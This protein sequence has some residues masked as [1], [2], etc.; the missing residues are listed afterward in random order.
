MSAYGDKSFN[1]TDQTNA[2]KINYYKRS[3][4]MYNSANMLQGRVRK[5]HNFTGKR[6]DLNIPLGFSGGVGSGQLPVS[7]AGE[8]GLATVIPKR[9]YATCQIEREAIYASKDDAGA[10]V[11]A[12]AHTVKKTV[13]S[14]MRNASRILWGNGYGVLGRGDGATVVTG[15]GSVATPYLVVISA[16]SW[17][18]CNWEEKDFVQHLSGL[19][20]D[21]SG[22]TVEGG[23]TSKTNLLEVV[24]VDVSTRQ[25]GLVGTSAALAALV[26]GPAAL[27]TTSGF[28][29]QRSY[30]REPMGINGA[31]LA[32]TG[33]LYGIT[34]QRRWSAYQLP[35]TGLGVTPDMVNQ[36]YLQIHKKFGQYPNMIVCGYEQY[37]NMLDL[38]EEK[39]QFFLPNLNVKGIKNAEQKVKFG[40]KGVSWLTPEGEIGVFLDRFADKDKIY[41]L[42][43][44][45]I[46]VHHRPGF[47][48]FQ[49]DGTVFLRDND[50]DMYGARYGGYYE[51][52]II[53]T[54]HGVI[55]GLAS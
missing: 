33:S 51:N 36:A 2:F 15:N 7:N 43:D 14:F 53:P 12:T 9:V 4:N 11:R 52:L 8:E 24:S 16:A 49:D 46:E 20:A 45:F 18:E 48:W 13:E 32:T 54:A 26:A 39:K 3:D 19:A 40:F 28:S 50:E 34:I 47:G 17:K 6:R 31:L 1:L 23:V 10:F 21:D 55:T 41:L 38:M 5:L 30:G 44:K 27:A 35:K 37:Q 42:N 25:I 29:M 22:A